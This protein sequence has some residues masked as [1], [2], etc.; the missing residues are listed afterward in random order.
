MIARLW[1]QGTVEA[2]AGKY[3]P[4]FPPGV[5]FALNSSGK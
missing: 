5:G 4:V 3:Y 2:D 1:A